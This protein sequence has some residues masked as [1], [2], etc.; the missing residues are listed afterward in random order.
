MAPR[1]DISRVSIK[2]NEFD[3]RI[4]TLEE[5]HRNMANRIMKRVRAIEEKLEG[6]K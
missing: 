2:L 4:K 3:K 5:A 6:K 1:V